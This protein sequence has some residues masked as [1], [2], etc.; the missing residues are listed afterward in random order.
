MMLAPSGIMATAS[1]TEIILDIN[2]L[3]QISARLCEP[4]NYLILGI[5]NISLS[6]GC[7][8]I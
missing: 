3:L 2:I 1:F 7:S 4:L 6:S 8:A 5:S